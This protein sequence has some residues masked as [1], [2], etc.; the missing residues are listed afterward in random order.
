MQLRCLAVQANASALVIGGGFAGLA[1]AKV[2]GENG[3]QVTLVEQVGAVAP[4][5]SLWHCGTGGWPL[6]GPQP[7]AVLGVMSL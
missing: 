2:L 5:H 7:S 4:S 1:A 6:G 3:V